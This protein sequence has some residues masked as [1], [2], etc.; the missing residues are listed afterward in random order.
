MHAGA[1]MR[2]I[3]DT[4]PSYQAIR[5]AEVWLKYHEAPR[6]WETQVFWFWGPPGSGKS[7]AAYEMS[8]DLFMVPSSP[9]L[10][11]WDRYDSHEDVLID[12][13]RAD[14]CDFARFLKLIDRYEFQ[15]ECKGGFRQLRAKRIIVTSC[16][17]PWNCWYTNENLDQLQRRIT[18]I[19]SFDK[20]PTKK[21]SGWRVESV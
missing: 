13:F 2:V 19:K 14:Q 18:E 16:V 20:V 5:I 17:P 21:V 10:K 7:R 12:D 9:Q 3:T 11:W 8:E 1:N 6:D 15:V 4:A